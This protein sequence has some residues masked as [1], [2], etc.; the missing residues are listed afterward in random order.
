MPLIVM[1]GCPCSG[2]TFY[3]NEIKKYYESKN[4]IINLINE[5][6][7]NVDKSQIYLN[8]INEKNHRSLLKSEVEKKINNKTITIIDSLNYIKGSR[9]E[10]FCM[11]RNCKTTHCVIYI[12]STLEKCLENNKKNNNY[13]NEILKDL[14]CRME[15]PIQNN[16]W[17]CPL[18]VLYENDSIPFDNINI[19]LFEGKKLK[20]PISTKPEF[21]FDSNFLFN[22]DK[23]CQEIVNEILNKQDE[24]FGDIILN[25]DENKFVNIN[26]K[27]TPIQLK[28][29]KLEFIKI[30]K[31]HPPNNEKE[32]RKNFIEYI[33]TI[34]SR[35]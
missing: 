6:S 16:R 26:K 35:F 1:C 29:I 25:I 9:Y 14:F 18:Y 5:E 34:Q 20:D 2:K 32:I 4:Y 33:Q 3:A 13:S 15:E 7:L 27:F 21:V 17:D 10:F 28:K 11:V 24:N 22:L 12:K 23:N 8:N 19:S 31:S 30:S